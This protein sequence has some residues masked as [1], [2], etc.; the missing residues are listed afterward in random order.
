MAIKQATELVLDHRFDPKSC[1]HS[2]NGETTVLH[3]HH[4]ASLY[5]QLADDCS[6]LDAKKLLAEVSEE[7]FYQILSDYYKNHN[8]TNLEDRFKIAEEYYSVCGMG[9]MEVICAGP[10]SGEVELSHSHID[11]GW[12][13]KW[14]KRDKP[15]NFIT[16]GYIAAAF[17][18]AFGRE[19]KTYT[20]TETESIVSG[21][22]KSHFE[23]AVA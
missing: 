18:A 15:V 10:D 5:T 17:A 19:M 3:C 1:R 6:L 22:E 12:I 4:Y 2:L 21:A 13:K 9:K 14:G 16:S 11:E 20:V 8:V 7:T 23:V